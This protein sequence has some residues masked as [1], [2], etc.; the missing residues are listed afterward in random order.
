MA[1]GTESGEVEGGLWGLSSI[2]VDTLEESGQQ[3]LCVPRESA[4]EEE[5]KDID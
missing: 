4:E 1:E 2:K 5:E 3:E